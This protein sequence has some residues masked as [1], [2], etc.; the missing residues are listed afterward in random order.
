MEQT[1]GKGSFTVPTTAKAFRNGDLGLQRETADV[2]AARL[3]NME[4]KATVE[5]AGDGRVKITPSREVGD[6]EMT[7]LTTPGRLELWLLPK[8]ITVNIDDNGIVTAT[9]YGKKKITPAQVLQAGYFVLDG[10]SLKMDSAVTY[11][12]S[13]PAIAFSVKPEAQS[14]LLQIT[15]GHIGSQMMIVIDGKI[16]MSPVIRAQISDAGIIQGN[17]TKDEA[18]DLANLLN[19]G[20]LP[21]EV[22][23]VDAP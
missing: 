8:E 6:R 22:T 5:P 2:L 9:Q 15:S 13:K 7:A 1:F 17:F 20:Q 3:K 16:I 14:R 11:S 10:T 21:A 23:V 18:E 12:Q 4:I 19:A